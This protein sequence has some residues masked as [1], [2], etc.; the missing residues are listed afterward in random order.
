MQALGAQEV[1]FWAGGAGESDREA[2]VVYGLSKGVDAGE[3]K[4]SD[5][6]VAPVVI[7]GAF[8]AFVDAIQC[9]FP[10]LHVALEEAGEVVHSSRGI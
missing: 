6:E 9:V 5:V 10:L 1:A 8:D 4:P 7:L 3:E 2:E